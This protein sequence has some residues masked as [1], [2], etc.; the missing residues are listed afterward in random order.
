MKLA[1][2]S[3]LLLQLAPQGEKASIEGVVIRLGTGEPLAAPN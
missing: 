2:N 1:C 3:F